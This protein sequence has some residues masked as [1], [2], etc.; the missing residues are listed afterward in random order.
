VYD[1]TD[2]DS[3]S[4]VKEWVRE[5]KSV[6]GPDIPLCIAGNKADKRGHAVSEEDA[7]TYAASVNAT[8]FVT[9]A[10]TGDHVQD[11]FREIAT[12]VKAS[13]DEKSKTTS[14]RRTHSLLAGD[15]TTG[16]RKTLRVEDDSEVSKKG[17]KKKGGCC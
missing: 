1:I 6:V 12:K 10:K 11:I 2:V 5:L 9:S 8:H 7:K 3:F 4:K 13:G 15:V 17:Q 16:G 14:S